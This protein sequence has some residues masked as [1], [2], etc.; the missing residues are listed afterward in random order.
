MIKTI[1]VAGLVKNDNNIVRFCEDNWLETSHFAA[2]DKTGESTKSLPTCDAAIIATCYISHALQDRVREAYA[3]KP[4]FFYN[5]GLSEIKEDLSKAI[6]GAGNWHNLNNSQV[7]HGDKFMFVLASL[8]KKGI[9]R[10]K[11]KDFCQRVANMIRIGFD[12]CEGM[13]NRCMENG[14]LKPGGTGRGQY[15]DFQPVVL[16]QIIHGIQTRGFFSLSPDSIFMS[17]APSLS[18]TMI[19]PFPKIE[20]ISIE[21]WMEEDWEAQE[22]EDELSEDELEI[23]EENMAGRILKSIPED[24]K[25][26]QSDDALLLIIEEQEKQRAMLSSLDKK[27]EVIHSHI[28][29]ELR[30]MNVARSIAGYLQTLPVDELERMKKVIEALTGKP[31]ESQS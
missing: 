8:A 7:P 20:M 21:E 4:L 12:H 28:I 9:L 3:E 30:S 23:K 2:S 31:L 5:K 26:P 15:F 25:K 10:H 14:S 16:D 11:R 6:W 1:L 27:M 29:Q 22:L 19:Q 24:A 17:G 18:K 13:F